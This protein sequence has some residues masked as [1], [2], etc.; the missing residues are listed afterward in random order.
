MPP[1]WPTRRWRRPIRTPLSRL[2]L[3]RWADERSVQ[4][5]EEDDATWLLPKGQPCT[6]QMIEPSVAYTLMSH[7]CVCGPLYLAGPEVALDLPHI[8]VGICWYKMRE[9]PR[10]AV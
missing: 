6:T 2:A 9:S 10:A 5:W 4:K 8:T 1:L 7:V 3:L